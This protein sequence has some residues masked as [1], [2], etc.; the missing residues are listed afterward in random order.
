LRLR[1]LVS[2]PGC[3][4]SVVAYVRGARSY[5]ESSLQQEAKKGMKQLDLHV[6]VP[7]YAQRFKPHVEVFGAAQVKLWPF[8]PQRFPAGCVVQDFCGR[9]GLEVAPNTIDRKKESLS[10]GAVSMLMLFWRSAG[11]QAGATVSSMSR[12]FVRMVSEA[13]G[14]K[15]RLSPEV[16]EP[17][18]KKSR[19][20]FDWIHER[21][22]VRMDDLGEARADDVR[23]TAD[24]LK[25]QP[26]AQEWLEE[27]LGC[28]FGKAPEPSELGKALRAW[29]KAAEKNKRA[30]RP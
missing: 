22:E 4:V 7:R 24:L 6:R 12:R 5:M 10:R 8:E 11:P 16:L 27:K 1:E 15:L 23:N 26:E 30:I 17:L 13:P 21:M 18:F 28:S 2:R 9:L 25:L 14:P 29:A 19:P 20:E 3:D